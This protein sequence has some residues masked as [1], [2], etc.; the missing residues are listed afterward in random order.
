MSKK[1]TKRSS[2]RS[3]RS[4]ASKP[5]L[6][7]ATISSIIIEG[8][9]G[10]FNYQIPSKSEENNISK[11]LIL[12]G[13]N[14]TGKTTILQLL[15]DALSSVQHRGLKTRL[16]RTPFRSLEVKFNNGSR[17]TF[18]KEANFVGPFRATFF[19]QGHPPKKILVETIE[20]GRVIAESPGTQ[21]LF[22]ALRELDIDFYF[23]TD[24]R[25]FHSTLFSSDQEEDEVFWGR[26]GPV[27][28]SRQVRVRGIHTWVP[29]EERRAQEI[30]IQMAIGRLERWFQQKVLTGSSVGDESAHTVLMGVL[31]EISQTPAGHEEASDIKTEFGRIK[32]LSK[33]SETFSSFG[34]QRVLPA[35]DFK[36]VLRSAKGE[37]RPLVSSVLHSYLN[38]YEA[39]LDALQEIRDLIELFLETIN[40]Y[41]T[42]KTVSFSLTEGLNI[43]LP[44]EELLSPKLLSSGEKQLLL[45]LCNTL[46][47]RDRKSIFL[48]DEPELSLNVTW[49]RKLLDSLM[50]FVGDTQNQFIIA[51]H[52][53]ELLA[54]HRKEVVKLEI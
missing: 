6:E 16:A 32:A 18:R 40:S 52:S 41:F 39:K 25:A 17:V 35:D 4:Q 11:L 44:K 53:L 48:I 42:S 54:R 28:V 14:G 22:K 27:E 43:H 20:D 15:F 33:R 38:G 49:Q 10:K 13:E 37:V 26:D 31:R 5:S 24:D 8:L 51:T 50:R 19:H 9:F 46:I 29:L 36:R 47:A 1:P 12:Y 3:K 7:S 30:E 2:K 21:D 34:L 45:L 23:L